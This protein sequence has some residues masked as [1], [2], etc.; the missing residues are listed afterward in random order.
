MRF[1][2]GQITPIKDLFAKYKERL[3]APQKTV[4]LCFIKNV[5]EVTGL[6]LGEHEV[7]YTV[8]T[9][10][11]TIKAASIKRQEILLRKEE[12]LDRLK[13]ELGK[14]ACPEALI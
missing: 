13:K 7:A 12:L 10:T 1:R 6:R 4:E 5:G 3:I 2:R 11:L 14:N 9:R 8:T